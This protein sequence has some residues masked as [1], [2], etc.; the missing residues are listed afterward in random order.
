MHTFECTRVYTL[1]DVLM[2]VAGIP[3]ALARDYPPL[4]LCGLCVGVAV[5]VVIPGDIPR[6]LA[7]RAIK[8]GWIE[9]ISRLDP[10]LRIYVYGDAL[11]LK[12]TAA[13]YGNLR[14][15]QWLIEHRPCDTPDLID[16]AARGGRIHT[17]KYL[18]ARG[19]RWSIHT[20]T[21]AACGGHAAT[22]SWLAAAGCPRDDLR[23][24]DIAA[25]HG[26]IDILELLP[27]ES[28]SSFTA[29]QAFFGGSTEA[30][31]WL[32][33]RGITAR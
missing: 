4:S 24:G 16:A 8:H 19:R 33:A 23:V 10:R 14:S 29:V 15:L 21:A 9:I 5:S 18:R 26:Y 11:S 28:F 13:V 32:A 6:W 7:R 1:M 12:A 17:I 27:V 3:A 22:L 30:T 2:R 20:S 31:R 25:H